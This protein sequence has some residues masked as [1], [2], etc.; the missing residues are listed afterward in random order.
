MSVDVMTRHRFTIDE[1][2]RMGEAGIFS[3]DDRVELINGE[4][5]EMTPIGSQHAGLVRRLDRWL[6]R[7]IGDE[8]LV[9]AQQPIKIATDGEPVPDIA[10]L[11]PRADDY[12]RSHPTPEDALLLIEVADTSGMYDRNV[13]RRLYAEGG[14]PEYWVV[15]MPNACVAVFRQPRGDDFVEQREYSGSDSWTSP[16]LGGREVTAETVLRGHPL[17]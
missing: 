3:E 2:H 5:V 11:R 17:T 1:Y 6:Q 7:W 16:A 4:I 13:K 15:D 9:S 10:L 8:V 14:V 12:I